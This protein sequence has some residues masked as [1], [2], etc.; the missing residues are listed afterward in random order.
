MS[1]KP[2]H[3]VERVLHWQKVNAGVRSLGEKKVIYKG[4]SGW[5]GKVETTLEVEYE[6]FQG[7]NMLRLRTIHRQGMSLASS[8][9][10]WT[11]SDPDHPVELVSSL[12]KIF[13]AAMPNA[14]VRDTRGWLGRLSDR[15]TGRQQLNELPDLA[16]QTLPYYQTLSA[17]IVN[18]PDGLWVY[19]IY[20]RG[21]GYSKLYQGMPM[22]ALKEL[23]SFLL[24]AK[25]A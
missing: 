21:R 13:V 14:P 1:D 11:V 2:S 23:H 17:R 12:E 24:N 22:E 10:T 4:F 8:G 9:Y 15:I 16:T 25:S 19:L 7:Q 18:T 20:D 5:K 6:S 3:P